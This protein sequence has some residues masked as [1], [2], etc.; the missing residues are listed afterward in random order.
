MGDRI[1]NI[2]SM[3]NKIYNR[4]RYLLL[5]NHSFGCANVCSTFIIHG[6]L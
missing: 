6:Q 5:F 2:N 4:Q 3:F 1:D